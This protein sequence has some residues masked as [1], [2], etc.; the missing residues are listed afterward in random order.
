M[1]LPAGASIIQVTYADRTVRRSHVFHDFAALGIPDGDI[2]MPYS[3][4][5]IDTPD[6]VLIVD[7]GFHVPDAYWAGDSIWRG[8]P[9]ALD[10]VG[11][12]P[13]AVIGVVLTHL[14]FDHAG[15]VGLFPNARIFVAGREL[16]HWRSR[17][18]EEQRAGFIDPAHLIAIERAERDG[19]LVVVEGRFAAS[20][21]AIMIPAPGHTP[22]Q[23][24][25]LASG[26][27]GARLLASDAVHLF[28][29][30]EHGWRFFAYTD[31]AAS[32]RSIGLLRRISTA[33]GAPI[34][35]GH[36]RRVRDWYPALP[37]PAEAFATILA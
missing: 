19:R 7:T 15:H 32:D 34:I 1:A 16:R 20:P 9:E 27:T 23:M 8:V 28:E 17:S 5:A 3:L 11:I 24:A 10:A 12:D 37:G 22:G 36:D 14:H 35:P 6:G 18:A 30:I 2:Q 33:T 26:P 31:A 4:W 25:V 29:Q 13:D 21:C